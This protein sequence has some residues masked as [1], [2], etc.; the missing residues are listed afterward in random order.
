[1]KQTLL[2]NLR[3]VVFDSVVPFDDEAIA[4]YERV[5]L[6][7]DQRDSQTNMIQKSRKM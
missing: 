5:G 1:M 4:A 2:P 3:L 7:L 6:V